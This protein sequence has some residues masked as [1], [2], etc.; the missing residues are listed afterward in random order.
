VFLYLPALHAEPGSLIEVR[1]R[2]GD[3]MRQ[4]FIPATDVEATRELIQTLGEE[5]DVYIG[6]VARTRE[7][8][9]RDAL[10]P[11]SLLWADCDGPEAVE[12]LAA[13]TP[14]PSAAAIAGPNRKPRASGAITKSISALIPS[15]ASISESIAAARRSGDRRIGSMSLNWIPGL[16]QSGTLRKS[17]AR[18]DIGRGYLGAEYSVALSGRN[19]LRPGFQVK[20]RAAG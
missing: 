18:I 13:F 9:G 5:T 15:L 6:A 14:A 1:Y 16:G 3:G 20:V 2:H 4:R 7:A 12:E 11:V 19:A 8:G 17:S 10:G